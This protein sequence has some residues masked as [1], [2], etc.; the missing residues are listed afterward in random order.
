VDS[1]LIPPIMPIVF[2]A[3]SFLEMMRAQ[4][5]QSQRKRALA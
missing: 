2:I 5:A 4:K 1:Q 3:V